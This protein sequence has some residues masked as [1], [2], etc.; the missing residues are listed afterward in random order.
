[1]GKCSGLLIFKAFLRHE[2]MNPPSRALREIQGRRKVGNHVW[3][4]SKQ[5]TATA[6]EFIMGY[7]LYAHFQL[8]LHPVP[9]SQPLEGF[10][11]AVAKGGAATGQAELDR[12][13][14]Q[15]GWVSASC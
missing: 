7:H 5:Q 3:V 2:L 15:L 9:Q 13:G 8:L 10:G 14:L 1:M 12:T 11:C 4:T 6:R